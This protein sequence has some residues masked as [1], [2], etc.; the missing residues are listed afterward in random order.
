MATTPGTDSERDWLRA[1][2]AHADLSPVDLRFRELARG[3]PELLRCAGANSPEELAVLRFHRQPW[4]LF[5]ARRRLEAMAQAGV[6]ISQLVRSIPQRLFGGDT[7]RMAS[8]Y[9][10]DASWLALAFTPPTGVPEGLARGDFIDGPAGF[11]CA[12]LNFGGNIG[13]LDHGLMGRMT[14]ATPAVQRFVAALGGPVQHRDSYRLLVRYVV[15]QV[16]SAGLSRG[17]INAALALSSIPA[18]R[19]GLVAHLVQDYSAVLAAISPRLRGQLFACSYSEMTARSDGLFRGAS[20]LHAVVEGDTSRIDRGVLA[21][22]KQGAIRFYNGPCSSLLSDKRNLALLSERAESDLFSARERAVIDRHVPWSRL[23]TPGP[24]VRQGEREDLERLVLA[25]RE[26]LV[27]KRGRSMAGQDVVI[28]R[29]T[30]PAAWEAGVRA[31]LDKGDW[32][33][34]EH[35]PSRRYLFQH[36]GGCCVHTAI[37]GPYIFGEQYGGMLLRVQPEERGGIVNA[38]Y[39]ATGATLLEVDDAPAGSA[40]ELSVRAAAPVDRRPGSD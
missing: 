13:G 37:W 11:R 40:A 31:A 9:G 10:L 17:E 12:E 30:A 5:I 35:V 6:A 22:F 38:T 21:C 19:S 33:V 2:E 29:E 24:V 8:F 26:E 25:R 39:G 16:L 14:L 1:R 32:I 4:P 7:R 3:D 15:H 28:G 36:A 27:I 20:R 34:Q 23:L 18:E